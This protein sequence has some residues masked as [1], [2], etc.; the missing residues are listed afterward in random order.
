MPTRSSTPAGTI[1]CTTAP[2]MPTP[3][4]RDIASNAAATLSSSRRPSATP[5]TSLLCTSSGADA[6]NAT[7]NPISRAAARAPSASGTSRWSTTGMPN[8]LTRATAAFGSSHAPSGAASRAV[9]TIERARSMSMPLSRGTT[10]GGRRRQ[11]ARSATRPSACA[12]DSGNAYDGMVGRVSSPR[13]ASGTPDCPRKHDRIGLPFAAWAA[14]PIARATS[15]ARVTSGGTKIAITASIEAS[16]SVIRNA[17]SYWPAVAPA[18]RSTGFAYR[19]A[20]RGDLAQRVLGGVVEHGYLEACTR[21]RV[22]GEDA[23]S[24]GVAD[25]RDPAAAGDRLMGED[26]RGREQL[27]ERVD[28]D[29]ARLAEQR[30][31]GDIGCGQRRG[32]RRRGTTAGRGASDLH[33]DDRFGPR[34]VAREPDELPRVPER[35]EVEEDHVG[36]RVVGPEL[37]QVVAADVGLVADRD[38]L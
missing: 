25:D 19:R 7:G 36:L 8:E 27:V 24:A 22:G 16:A 33:R 37:Q 35:L 4:E 20:R 31:D 18:T 11:S 17:S 1:G 14:R 5:P 32:V 3:S 15:S 23:G 30:V 13:S 29:H 26:H 10:P 6:F 34:D 9:A 38:E 21:A 28:A 2:V 12:A